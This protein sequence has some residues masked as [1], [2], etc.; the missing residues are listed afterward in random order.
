MIVAAPLRG[1]L[2]M[3][4][5]GLLLTVNDAVMKWLTA[6]Y[7]LG[8][9]LFLRGAFV[10]LPIALLTWQT[11][12][13]AALRVRNVPGQAVRA[14]AM[15]CSSFLFIGGLS[16]LPLADAIAL[17]FAG[18]L[19]LTAL[20]TPMLGERVG[21]RRWS[22]VL[23]G[24]AGVLVM[25]RPTGEALYWAALLPLGAALAGAFRDV[26]TRRIAVTETTIGILVV[27]TAA[28]TLAGLCTAPFGWQP[29]V[30]RDIGLFA[31][32]GLLLGGAHYLMIESFRFAEVALVAPF[33]YASMLW[34][35]LF[36]FLVWG[37][38]PDSWMLTGSAMV[39]ASGLYILHRETRGS[40][41]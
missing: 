11:G 23:I 7:P 2:C 39:I 35:T 29:L 13:F 38:L 1:I 40:R 16:L 14:A 9:V 30:A 24:F 6:D 17:S 8:Q 33:K 12:G 10:F 27:S 36:G 3:L 25:L 21:W 20:A 15:I 5:G 26:F 22:A 4:G 34:A 32:A 37:H 18:P 28:V 19:F 31:L 41:M